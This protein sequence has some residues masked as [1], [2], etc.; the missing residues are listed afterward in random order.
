MKNA[1]STVQIEVDALQVG[2][3]IHLDMGWMSHPFPLSSFRISSRQQIATI[4]SLG[5][6]KL[7]WNPEQSVLAQAED[8]AQAAAAAAAV[9]EAASVTQDESPEQREQ[10]EHRAAAARERAAL[11]LC[12]RQFTEATH[13]TRLLTDMIASQPQEARNRA[14][15]LTRA[16]AQKMMGEREVC[17]RLLTEAAGERASA[18][19]VNVTLI[20]MLMGRALGLSESEML[21]L[22]VGALLHDMGKRDL[23]PRVRHREDHFGPG[24]VK[25][26]EE[27]VTHGVS[28]ALRMGLSPGAALVIAQHHEHADGSGF[29][30]KLGHERMTP[31]SCIVA[32]VNRYDNLCNPHVASRAFTPHEALSLL[33]A[34]GKDKFDTAILSTF[35]KMM[36]VYPPGSIVQLTDDRYGMVTSVNASRP[37][38]PRVC[39]FAA[40]V[41][42]VEAPV[43]DLEQM[44][45][46]GIRR[47]VRPA[48]VPADA[49]GNLQPRPR[50]AYFFEAARE[51]EDA[52]A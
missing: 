32:L 12:E 6:K 36:G 45:K 24:E 1:G 39:V 25:F 34:Q 27:H 15:A 49:V 38:K 28:H 19:A 14:Q 16:L 42:E 18:H 51:Q 47:S 46:L 3:F 50:V 20:S 33:F 48:A 43:I 37:L 41:P 26:Y 44:P 7:R 30:L 9:V 31:A 5:V 52:L 2:M 8:E 29:P 22:G 4:R 35:I 21:D 13:E 11:A 17:I 10:R 40:G 23:P